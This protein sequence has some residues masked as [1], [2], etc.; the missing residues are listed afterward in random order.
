MDTLDSADALTIGTA[1]HNTM[2]SVK[3]T[4]TREEIYALVDKM[5]AR[6]IIPKDVKVDSEKI[7]NAVKVVGKIVQEGTKYYSE[8]Q[9]I[10][11]DKHSNLVQ[12]S[13]IDDYVIIQGVLDLVVILDT[14]AIII[15]FKTNKSSEDS[16]KSHYKLQLD[17]YARA[18]EKA[19]NIGVIKKYLYSF[20]LNKLIDVT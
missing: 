3:Y 14:G 16:M 11:R 7:Y 1:Y 9:F 5:Y 12:G 6:G 17:L 20:G 15:D 2:Q 10:F 4:E 18:F 8:K 19:Y 13:T